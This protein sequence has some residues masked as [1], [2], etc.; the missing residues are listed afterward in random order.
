MQQGMDAMM[1][2]MVHSHQT[3]ESELSN[4]NSKYNLGWVAVMHEKYTQLYSSVML[5]LEYL[6]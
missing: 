4:V 2:D 6:S 3:K 1:Q 5:V